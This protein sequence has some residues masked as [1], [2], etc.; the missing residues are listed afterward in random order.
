MTSEMAGTP[1]RTST[2]FG[3]VCAMQVTSFDVSNATVPGTLLN[4]SG[5]RPANRSF[6]TEP[7]SL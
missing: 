7:I 3:P 5:M 6:R 1:G 4:S 2:G